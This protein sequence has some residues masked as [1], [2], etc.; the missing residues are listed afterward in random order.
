[1]N[2]KI[3]VGNLNYRTEEDELSQLFNQFGNV[4][5]AVIIMDRATNRSKGFG[6][7]TFESSE[8]AESALS[9]NDQDFNGRKIAVKMAKPQREREGGHR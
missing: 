2:N 4:L 6:F 8:A 7:I 1:M 3:Y 9:L 5:E